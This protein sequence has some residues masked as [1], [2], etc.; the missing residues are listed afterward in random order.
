MLWRS[1]S[2]LLLASRALAFSASGNDN[3]VVYWG[4]NSAGGSDTQEQLSYYCQDDAT[5]ILVLSFLNIFYSTGDLP[6]V[7]FG[8]A[9]EGTYFDGTNL[10]HCSQIGDDIKT[11]Q[12]LGKKVLLS[13]GGASGSYGFT[14]DTEA[15]SFADELWDLFGGGSSDTRPFDDAIVDGFDLDIEGG[16]STGYGAFANRMKTHYDSASKDYY[17]SAA[18]QCP[19]PDAFLNSALTTAPFDFIFVQFYNNY[20]GMQNWASGDSNANF[21]YDSW[22]TFV[23]SESYNSDAKVYLGVPA[24]SSAAGSGYEPASTVVEAANYLQSTYNTFGGVMMWDA[25]QAWANAVSDSQNFAQ[26]VKAG[27]DGGAVDTGSSSSADAT[28]TAATSTP[29]AVSSTQAQ[30]TSTIVWWTPEA[31]STATSSSIAAWEPTSSAAAWEPSSSSVAAWEPSSSSVAAWEPTSSSVAAWEPTSSSVAAWEP[32]SSVAVSTESSANLWAPSSSAVESVPSSSVGSPWAPY[33]SAGVDV[34]SASSVPDAV[35]S[36]V[37]SATPFGQKEQVGPTVAVADATNS[38]TSV[39][40]APSESASSVVMSSSLVSSNTSTSVVSSVVS[41]VVSSV[42]SSS[43]NSS[44][45]PSFASSPIVSS[46]QFVNST[47]SSVAPPSTAAPVSSAPASSSEVASS[48]TATSASSSSSSSSSVAVESSSAIAESSSLP[49]V[50]SE[51][52]SAESSQSSEVQSSSSAPPAPETSSA[53]SSSVSTV[54]SSAAPVS[55]DESSSASQTPVEQTS[56]A[57]PAADQT[58]SVPEEPVEP[59]ST[60]TT[61]IDTTLTLES[62]TQTVPAVESPSTSS[63]STSTPTVPNS[64]AGTDPQTVATTSSTSVSIPADVSGP[65]IPIASLTTNPAIPTTSPV[66]SVA[67]TPSSSIAAVTSAASSASAS[68]SSVP[69]G[70]PTPGGSCSVEGAL[71]C[72]GTAFAQCVYGEWVVRPCAAGTVCRNLNGALFCAWPSTP[73]YGQCEA[74]A[75][76]SDSVSKRSDGSRALEGTVVIQETDDS[77]FQGVVHAYTSTLDPIGSK[78]VVSFSLDPT[79]KVTSASRGTLENNGSGNYTLTA[80]GDEES[81]SQYMALVATISGD[82]SA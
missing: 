7:N 34:S 37:S 75:E 40:V 74:T 4:Q 66:S 27:L 65:L 54:I 48:S 41:P 43:A 32:S 79:Y 67:V 46:A 55:T 15:E 1:L 3:V 30:S 44:V 22:D 14:D 47:I 77:H 19:I 35:A 24:S 62:S 61:S 56:S 26:A 18:P 42:V 23:T 17:L 76:T 6:A 21:N 51:T 52:S 69:S 2:V 53:S 10:L 78:W 25:S 72:S 39:S 64:G 70:C 71:E 50:T 68:S 29:A 9:C 49:V 11:C 5:D 58:S 63:S 81:S 13:L 33:S 45:A 57:A 38:S 31:A 16:T 60:S 73:N 8:N 82:I 28:S 12:S 80:T 36:A 20:C 59:T